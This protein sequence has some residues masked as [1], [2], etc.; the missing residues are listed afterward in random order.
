MQNAEVVTGGVLGAMSHQY[1]RH[2]T[3]RP[4]TSRIRGTPSRAPTRRPGALSTDAPAQPPPFPPVRPVLRSFA[5]AQTP[6]F[7]LFSP[8][9]SGLR[10]LRPGPPAETL[11]PPRR[12]SGSPE[13]NPVPE[14]ARHVAKR[15]DC[16]VFR[17][18]DFRRTAWSTVLQRLRRSSTDSRSLSQPPIPAT[19]HVVSQPIATCPKNQQSPAHPADAKCLSINILHHASRGSCQVLWT[20][21]PGSCQPQLTGAQHVANAASPLEFVR[22]VPKHPR[23]PRSPRPPRQIQMPCPQHYTHP[24]IRRT[25]SRKQPG[26]GD[27]LP[28]SLR[29]FPG[30]SVKNGIALSVCLRERV[31]KKSE[32]VRGRWIRCLDDHPWPVRHWQAA[33]KLSDS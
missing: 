31:N 3:N 10:S 29:P 5:A 11:V 24:E 20:P 22:F 1:G 4:D 18:V 27:K 23:S 25:L 7:P 30:T 15:L 8:V 12:R 21:F 13:S 26:W 19:E 2:Y 28:S 33:R 16:A 32:G 6:L 17:R 14:M 9:H